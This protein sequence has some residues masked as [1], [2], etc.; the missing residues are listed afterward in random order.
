MKNS[1]A[2]VETDRLKEI[3]KR[4]ADDVRPLVGRLQPAIDQTHPLIER[5]RLYAADAM[6]PI[7]PV[8]EAMRPVVDELRPVMRDLRALLGELLQRV[9]VAAARIDV[10]PLKSVARIAGDSAERLASVRPTLPSV[11]A[12]HQP[13]ITAMRVPSVRPRIGAAASTLAR[14]LRPGLWAFRT[15]AIVLIGLVMSQPWLRDA[16]VDE[17]NWTRSV[18]QTIELPAIQIPNVELPAFQIPTIEI[19]T[20]LF[21]R[22]EPAAPKLAPAPFEVPPLNAYRAAFEAQAAYPTVPANTTVEWVIALRNTGSAGWYRG[23]AGAQASL[24]LMDGTEAAVQTTAYVAPGQVGWFI[25]HFRAPAGPGA[26]SVALYPRIDGRGELPNL[27]I[28]AL[29]TVR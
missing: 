27:G 14:R 23:V 22:Q 15:S 9:A 12:I 7:V 13:H 11:G 26:H 28:F 4:L 2:E 24:A 29:V 5:A 17:V 25:A 18:V 10:G 16:M 19:P 6:D 21:A 20:N 8:V 3:T 1:H